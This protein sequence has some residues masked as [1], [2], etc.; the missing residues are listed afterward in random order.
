MTDKDYKDENLKYFLQYLR[1][2]RNSSEHTLKNYAGDICQFAFMQKK[3]DLLEKPF[4]WSS[5]SIEDAKLF[6]ANL[7][8]S[9][10]S[11]SSLIRKISSLRSFFKY[12]LREQYVSSNPFT[13][14]HSIKKEKK[15]PQ[16]MS[17]S[18]VDSLL[19]APKKYWTFIDAEPAKIKNS[20]E[21][22][23]RRDTAILELIYSGGLRISEATNLNEEDIDY[24]SGAF[25]VKGKGKKERVCILGEPAKKALKLYLRHREVV[26]LGSKSGR[27]PLF[28]NLKDSGRLTP[29][30]VQ[31]N[32]KL[33]VAYVDLA[34]DLTP[35]KLRHSFATHLLDAGADLRYVQ[36]MLGHASLSTTQIYTH[37][38]PE[39]L[40]KAYRNA[41]PHA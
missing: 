2:E 14:L 32:F 25:T 8:Q 15:L 10:L 22:T 37:I 7:Q 21:F 26:Q 29:R 23:A 3:I 41:H 9:N 1:V 6:V 17:I 24:I 20:H 35:H 40:L 18:Q 28:I 30:S 36:E 31:R 34:S 11:R 39:R 5:I 19:S 12:Q 13:L 38:T 33:Y 16:I 4:P 27:G